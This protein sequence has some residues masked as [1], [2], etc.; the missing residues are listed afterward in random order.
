MAASCFAFTLSA[1]AQDNPTAT[2]SANPAN[3]ASFSYDVVSI[4]PHEQSNGNNGSRALD[5]GISEH[6]T[7]LKVLVMEAYHIIPD[8]IIGLPSWG[9]SD[10]YDVDAKMDEQTAA[11]LQKLPG[12]QRWQ[13]K[14]QML[15]DVLADRFKLKIHKE[16]RE[17]TVYNLV[18]A[19]GGLKVRESPDGKPRR[20]SY[21]PGE[22]AGDG[23][24]MNGLV[25]NLQGQVHSI[26]VDKT[27]LT[28]YYTIELKWNPN[29]LS[30]SAGPISSPNADDALPD[31]PTALQDQL[32]LKLESTKAPVDVIVIDHVEKPSEN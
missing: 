13:T 32:G 3:S 11:A 4:K 2:N 6:D 27:G 26:V 28:G 31:L 9:N 17:M 25:V 8:Q 29:P 1:T 12:D 10:Q 7:I 22:I 20:Y 14:R 15:Q 18:I 16:T 21:R 30:A 19:K 23:I 5:N 24:S